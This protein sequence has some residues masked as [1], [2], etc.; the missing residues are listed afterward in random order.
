M[1][2]TK[3][4][5]TDVL[6]DADGRAVVSMTV[7]NDDNFL[8]TLSGLDG[9][10]ISGEIAEYLENS[11]ADL[12]ASE[13]LT[14]RIYSNCIDKDEETIYPEA[15]RK[16]YKKKHVGVNRSLSRNFMISTYLAILGIFTLLAAIFIEMNYASVLWAEVVDIVAWVLLW[17]TTDVMLFRSHELRMQKKR[18]SAFADIKVEFYNI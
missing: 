14:L 6:R 7:S 18:Y 16:Y 13:A 11:T 9:A 10:V 8:S 17:E 3:L 5:T 15:I 1:K 4:C 2:N 12:K